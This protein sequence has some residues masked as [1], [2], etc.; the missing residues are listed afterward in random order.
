M[1]KCLFWGLR[2]PGA[3]HG[4]LLAV[5][6][7]WDNSRGRDEIMKMFFEGLNPPGMA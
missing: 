5:G 2:L 7:A 1:N 4:D 3:A 6:T